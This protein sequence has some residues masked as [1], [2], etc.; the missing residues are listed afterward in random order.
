MLKEFYEYW[1]EKNQAGVK[2]RF[3]KEKTFEAGK[4]LARWAANSKFKNS[5]EKQDKNYD[6]LD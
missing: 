5:N 1:T 6:R 3:E 2:M 4:R